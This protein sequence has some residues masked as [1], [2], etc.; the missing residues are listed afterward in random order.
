MKFEFVFSKILWPHCGLQTKLSSK[1]H[2]TLSKLTRTIVHKHCSEG[3]SA[4]C[5]MK[6][7]QF[8][9]IIQLVAQ[10][11]LTD[12]SSTIVIS[13]KNAILDLFAQFS[14]IDAVRKRF[15]VIGNSNFKSQLSSSFQCVESNP[16][17]NDYYLLKLHMSNRKRK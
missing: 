7:S 6:Q 11:T 1:R 10:P 4:N 8:W 9:K 5:T 12:C 14:N 15:V 3:C 2:P 17:L 13:Q 16:V